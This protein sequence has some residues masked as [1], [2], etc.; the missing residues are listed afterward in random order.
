M[1]LL[2][3]YLQNIKFC[4]CVM[5]CYCYLQNIKYCVCVMEDDCIQIHDI[6]TRFCVFPLS[7][8]YFTF[9]NLENIKNFSLI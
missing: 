7:N 2:F 6:K 9:K 3:K 8:I 5:E 1:L 4:V